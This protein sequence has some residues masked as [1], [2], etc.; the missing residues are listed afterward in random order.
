MALSREKQTQIDQ[1]RS[2][3]SQSK[4]NHPLFRDYVDLNGEIK[5]LDSSICCVMTPFRFHRPLTAKAIC[6]NTI[7]TTGRLGTSIG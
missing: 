2:S 5:R 6:Q 1:V 7:T 3:V 4:A